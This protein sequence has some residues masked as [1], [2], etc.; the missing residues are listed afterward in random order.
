MKLS[1]NGETVQ[2]ERGDNLFD[3]NIFTV[4]E[5]T[6]HIKNILENTIS[7][8]WVKGEISNYKR[9]S[10]G[11]IYFTLKDENASLLC[12][13]FRQFNH[14]LRF[15]P[16]NGMEVLCYGKVTVYERSG[17]Y[18]L[19][20]NQMRPLGVGELEV[21]FRKLKEKLEAEGLF[22]EGH[23]RAIP[24]H[25]SKIGIVTSPTGAAIQDMKN[26]LSRR[27]PV[28][29]ILYPARVQGDSAAAEIAE[30]IRAFNKRDDIDVI[31]I[32]RGGG[33]IED[34][35]PFNEEIVAREIFASSIPI[36][37]AVG[38][39]TDFTISDFVADLRAPTPSAAAELV[40]PDR[41][42]VLSELQSYAS[43]MENIL[44][45]Q[46]QEQRMH[47]AELTYK[48]ERLH[49][50]QV[51]MQYYQR[52]DELHSRLKNSLSYITNI[53]FELEEMKIKFLQSFRS[54]YLDA[55]RDALVELS[56]RLGQTFSKKYRIVRDDFLNLSARLEELN[57]LKI[58]KSGYTLTK[59]GTR[60]L[61]TIKDVAVED[62]LTVHF[63]DGACKCDVTEILEQREKETQ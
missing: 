7:A 31:I 41:T 1:D 39:E 53:R 6:S 13:F 61:N 49:P 37:S 24:T 9:H 12:V 58:L 20:V 8:L 19:Y 15:E 44:Y 33:S 36:I 5:I 10:S 17:Q 46:L 26:V 2:K 22:D 60:I 27:Y 18:Q 4:S 45:S 25:P 29:I 57:P 40:V 32:G 56:S 38:H 47:C 3:E 11:H 35:W 23:K 54:I 48:L 14:Y 63:F 30:G 52:V 42:A 34:L 28:E 50:Q 21:A 62:V 55:N 16:E 43:R 51:L 59:K